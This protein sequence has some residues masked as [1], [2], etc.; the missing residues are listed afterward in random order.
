MFK[1]FAHGLLMDCSRIVKTTLAS[2]FLITQ[3]GAMDVGAPCTGNIMDPITD[4]CWDCL[5]PL[6]IG[7]VPVVASDKPDTDNPESP[8][9]I[10]KMP[11]PPYIRVGLNI[12]YWEPS[13]LADVTRTPYCMVNLG[14]MKID[15]GGMFAVGESGNYTASSD[16]LDG[17]IW[18]VHYYKYPLIY[19]L[20]IMMSVGCLQIGDMDI[21]Y[22]SELDPL[23]NDDEWNIIL[24]PEVLLFAN[25]IAQMACAA[26]AL[27][28]TP[29]NSAAIDAL[30]WC[31][32]NQGSAYPLN[33][34][35]QNSIGPI[36]AS[37][38]LTERMN[39][40]LHREGMI[41]DS[42]GEDNLVC[43]QYIDP[44]LPKSRYRYE[45]VNPIPDA[46][47]CHPFGHDTSVWGIGHD[48][49]SNGSNFGYLIWKKRNCVYL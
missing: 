25:P 36:Q 9:Q 33:G 21:A 26:D 18:N 46:N 5:F 19:W 41:L 14:G 2:I 40:K 7:S 47:D 27:K 1:G 10:C 13:S 8:V 45:M 20:N 6:T 16:D 29:P 48:S 42:I 11:Y 34:Y 32:G 37:T 24:N 49:V 3:A 38:L 4:M 12:N 28:T 39:F 30:F 35:V 15:M 23:W 43:H 31:M 44:I 17:S 22:L